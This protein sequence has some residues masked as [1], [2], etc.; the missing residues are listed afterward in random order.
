MTKDNKPITNNNQSLT[1]N[2]T[3]N[4]RAISLNAVKD[5]LKMA[6]M[7]EF[8]IVA[9]RN[10]MQLPPVTLQPKIGHWIEDEYEMEVRCSACGEENDMCSKYCPNCGARMVEPHERSDKG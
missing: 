10:I 4:D 8:D 7:E 9:Y 6:N 3:N 5:I 2:L 1:N